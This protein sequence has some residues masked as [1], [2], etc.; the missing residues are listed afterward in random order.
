MNRHAVAAIYRCEMARTFR[1]LGESL[2]SPVL[3][4]SLYFIVF[5]A[6]IG[7][8]MGEVDGVG[9]AA[10]IIP[11][12]IMLSLLNESISNASF[13]IYMPKWS[14]T[15]F[16]LLSAPVGVVEVILGYV[17]AAT[18]KSLMI[19]ALILITA[20]FFVPYEIEHPFWM[21][22]FLL[23]TAAS[24]SLFGFLIGLWA[25]DWQKLQI[26]PLMVMTPLT[27][28]GGAFYSISMLPPFWQTVS[29]FNP[30][31]YLISGMRW[32]FYG[33][34][35]VDPVISATMILGFF[36]ACLIAVAW[37]FR[38]GWRLRS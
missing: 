18:T 24:F 10:F 36:V 22:F 4:T 33:S 35:D 32:A 25:T 28:L 17:G 27:F 20:R 13:G 38:S 19:G 3:T 16:E 15:I 11:G 23:L 30:V 8:R 34:A 9:Y 2:L 14:G 1:T 26:V 6:A 12:L 5:G 7:S 31:V 21:L 29:L 37:I